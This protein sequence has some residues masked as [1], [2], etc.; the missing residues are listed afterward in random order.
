VNRFTP[1]IYAHR[2]ACRAAPENTIDAFTR[3]IA[4]GVDGIELDVRATRDGVLVVVHDPAVGGRA[5]CD[6][7]AADLRSSCP[8]MPTLE[9]ALQHCAGR[10]FLDVELK[11]RG[12]ERQ[13]I[14]LIERYITASG[15]MLTSF[16]QP[17][18]RAIRAA[19]PHVTCGLLVGNRAGPGALGRRIASALAVGRARRAG[20]H[21]V[22]PHWSLVTEKLL[23]GAARAG[24]RVVV[25][26]VDDPVTI[27]RLAADGR[28]AAIITN[29]PEVALAERARVT[30]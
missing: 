14:A 6:C 16:N 7:T 30:L 19:S 2:G 5:V 15:Y 9:E 17:S 26:T 13:A 1:H 21:V 27:G 25:W 28:V 23:A 3:A 11:E 29:E 10:T 18:I 12:H 22:A 20:A 8:A 24:L 4:M